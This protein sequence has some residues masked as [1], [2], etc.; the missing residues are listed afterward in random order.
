MR[1]ISYIA[2]IKALDSG[3][4]QCHGRPGSFLSF[5]EVDFRGGDSFFPWKDREE[6]SK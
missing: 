6:G 5:S 4:R 3:I 2:L 1:E